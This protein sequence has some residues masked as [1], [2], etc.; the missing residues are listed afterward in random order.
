MKRIGLIFVLLLSLV[1]VSNGFCADEDE[2][3]N[4]SEKVEDGVYHPA[5]VPLS[6]HVL[7]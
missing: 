7:F 4:L 2:D 5:P 6:Y 1:F 3:E